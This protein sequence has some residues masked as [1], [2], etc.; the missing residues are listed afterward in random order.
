MQNAV[1]PLPSSWPFFQ[2]CHS[3]KANSGASAPKPL[4]LLA[5]GW[6]TGSLGADVLVPSDPLLPPEK[7][8]PHPSLRLLLW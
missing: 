6:F 8:L 7:A 3:K 1:A 5:G 2:T 4:A